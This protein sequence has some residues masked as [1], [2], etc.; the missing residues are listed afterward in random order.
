MMRKKQGRL[1]SGP[2]RQ[3]WE[4]SHVH[5]HRGQGPDGLTGRAATTTAEDGRCSDGMSTAYLRHDESAILAGLFLPDYGGT[6]QHIQPK[7]QYPA[8]DHTT[9][10]TLRDSA[11]DVTAE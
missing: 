8:P 10:R 4:P 3:E 5:R 2:N 7:E 9:E 11:K 6:E 1:D